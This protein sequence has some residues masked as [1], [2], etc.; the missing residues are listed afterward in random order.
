MTD[1]DPRADAPASP[2][3]PAAPSHARP[4]RRH[5]AR[6]VVGAIACAAIVV[7]MLTELRKAEVFLRPVSYAVQHRDQQGTRFF[8]MG[9][10]V[11]TGSIHK[12]SDGT[13][14]T[15][16]EGGVT[17]PVV[18]HTDPPELFKNC[19]PVVV[20]GHWQGTTFSADQL[21]I[22]HGSEYDSKARVDPSCQAPTS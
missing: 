18:D 4:R 8:R 22:R 15:V 13:A 20:E 11:V 16:T 3:P 12:T 6:Y 2:V 1:T 7:W 5:H 10:T 17:A 19:A 21:L 14:F 9:G